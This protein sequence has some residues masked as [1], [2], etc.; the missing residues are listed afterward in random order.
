M[1]KK[2]LAFSA[3]SETIRDTLYYII[4]WYENGLTSQR[5]AKFIQE[6]F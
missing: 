2:I 1:K 6:A 5:M 4:N 3:R